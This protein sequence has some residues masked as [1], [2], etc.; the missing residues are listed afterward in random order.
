[1]N[2]NTSQ[3]T[4]SFLGI[5]GAFLVI[6][7]L[8]YAMKQYTRP[9]P[10]DQA[11]AAERKKAHLDLSAVS[12]NALHSYG[13]QDQAKGIVRLRIDRAMELTL[14]EYKNPPGV[15]SNLAARAVVAFP[16]PVPPPPAPPSKYE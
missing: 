6:A 9:A 8:V 16:A 3:K 12:D 13:W 10:L 4:A 15:R 14:Q 1:M 5:I 11:R 7:V 2:A